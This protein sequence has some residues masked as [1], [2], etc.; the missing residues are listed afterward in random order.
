MRS[1]FIIICTVPRSFRLLEELENGEKGG[2]STDISY[3]LADPTDMNLNYWTATIL[4]P[5]Y[6]VF[7]NRIY[8]VQLFCGPEYPRNPPL[9][10]FITKINVDFVNPQGSVLPDKIKCLREWQPN[11]T[12][13]TVL[14]ELKR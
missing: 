12:I 11:F 3:G 4:G 7:E 2:F 8:T 6:T 5:S 10:N 1:L 13:Q 14:E 9:V